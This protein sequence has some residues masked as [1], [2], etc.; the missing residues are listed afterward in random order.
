MPDWAGRCSGAA[1]SGCCPKALKGEKRSGTI[2]FGTLF[3]CIEGSYRKVREKATVI[4]RV[5]YEGW[6]QVLVEVTDGKM[7]E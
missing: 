1:R 6:P 3:A 7:G 4:G 2:L 5:G